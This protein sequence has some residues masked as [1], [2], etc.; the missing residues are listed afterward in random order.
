MSACYSVMLVRLTQ[1]VKFL[2][3]D[4]M[5]SADIAVARCLSVDP[6]VY[7]SDIRRYCVETAKCILIFSLYDSTMHHSRFYRATRMH[8]AIM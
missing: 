1:R 4:A 2:P 7:L 8:S 6:S 3:R 5:H